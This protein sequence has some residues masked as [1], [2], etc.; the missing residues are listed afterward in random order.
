MSQP[1]S[2][3]PPAALPPDSAILRVLLA[4]DDPVSRKVVLQL[5]SS[6]G[7]IADAVGTGREALDALEAGPYDVVLMDVEMPEMDGY[8]ATAEIRYREGGTGRH[9]P[10]IAIT[11]HATAADRHRCLVFG[12]DDFIAKP[13][14][15]EHV[16]AV[17]SRW[18]GD[19]WAP[20]TDA[21]ELPPAGDATS[22]RTA[23]NPN[24]TAKPATEAM[25]IDPARLRESSCGDA[26]FARQLV[27]DFVSC[28][29]DRIGELRS[30]LEE[31]DSDAVA[32]AAHSLKGASRTLGALLMGETAARLETL[33]GEGQLDQIGPLIER[34]AREFDEAR[35]A[36]ERHV[37]RKVA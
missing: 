17:L 5:L 32:Y 28:S 13:V 37:P 16:H 2:P 20:L 22:P 31:Q 14:D 3:N 18:A 21:A 8:E 6:W 9:I 12:M 24:A 4:E 36:L 27:D 30:A 7:V 26:N 25:P 23:A 33:A 34:L 15:P 10:I 29:N 35:V 11:S 1:P 19:H